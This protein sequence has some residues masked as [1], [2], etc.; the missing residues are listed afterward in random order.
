M[1]LL[2]LLLSGTLG[3]AQTDS[4]MVPNYDC[5]LIVVA[6]DSSKSFDKKFQA[7]YA[8]GSHGGRALTFEN[9]SE[10]VV[11]QAS[12]NWLALDWY[13]DGKLVAAGLTAS[14]DP[15]LGSRA[16]ILMNPRDTEE[17][18]SLDCSPEPSE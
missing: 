11:L 2:A 18:I 12:N 13:R 3:H 16:L 5:Q 9:G 4:F 17:Q 15:Y 6:K 7:D 10:K 1:T 14:S 8:S